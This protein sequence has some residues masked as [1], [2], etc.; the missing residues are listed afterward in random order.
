M[1]VAGLIV[2]AGV[3]C[4]AWVGVG[5]CTKQT[6]ALIGSARP[7]SWAQPLGVEGVPNLHRVSPGLYRS[8]QP[9]AEGLK[10]METMGVKTVVSLRAFH[11]DREMLS[12]TSMKY[13]R[14]SVKS[15]HIEKEDALRFLKIVTD[16]ANQP[17]LVHCLHGA[18]RTGTMCAVYRMAVEGWSK[19]DAI[20]EL[21]DGG[22]GFHEVWENMKKWLDTVNVEELRLAIEKK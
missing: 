17:V 2:V 1:V 22:Y 21:T 8:A 6:P 16:P 9:T 12:G 20:K 18:D 15:W 3:A 14:I 11:S 4:W 13:E 10:R 7:A 5:A 19:E